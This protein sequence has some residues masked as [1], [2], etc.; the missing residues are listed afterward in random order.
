VRYG[1]FL[2]SI[3]HSLAHPALERIDFGALLGITIL[4]EAI[5]IIVCAHVYFASVF[6]PKMLR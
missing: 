4:V 1:A 6:R 2:K 5:A 3:L